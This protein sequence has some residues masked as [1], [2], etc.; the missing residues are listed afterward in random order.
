MSKEK[1]LY[2]PEQ[3]RLEANAYVKQLRTEAD[4]RRSVKELRPSWRS[5]AAGFLMSLAEWLE[6]SLKPQTPLPEHFR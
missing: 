4:I 5:R 6:P 2:L 3:T 1:L